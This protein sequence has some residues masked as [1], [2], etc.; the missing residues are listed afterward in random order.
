[1]ENPPLTPIVRRIFLHHTTLTHVV[2]CHLARGNTNKVA[3][4]LIFIL[5]G[6]K[7]ATHDMSCDVS[8]KVVKRENK[9]LRNSNTAGLKSRLG[10]LTDCLAGC[11]LI[12]ERK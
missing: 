7:Q 11:T 5:R 9:H 3:Q 2:G 1:M 12:L 4:A 10:V 6:Q 8:G